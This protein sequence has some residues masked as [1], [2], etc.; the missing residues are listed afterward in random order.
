MSDQP[1][2]TGEWFC[3]K[4]GYVG[5]TQ[6]HGGCNYN[7]APIKPTGEWTV[8][9]TVVGGD[10]FPSIVCNGEMVWSTCRASDKQELKQLCDAH[11][12]AVA[13]ATDAAVQ[14]MLLVKH[15]LAAELGITKQ[16]GDAL[17]DIRVGAPDVVKQQIKDA[18]AKVAK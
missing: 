3:N 9:T 7:A 15:Q 6:Q 5:A 18:L 13:E 16:L 17:K 4:C 10:R 14:E 12:A 1:K 2:P 8:G 11:N